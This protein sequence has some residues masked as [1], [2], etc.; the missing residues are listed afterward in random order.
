[1]A[2]IDADSTDLLSAIA[3]IGAVPARKTNP[4]APPKTNLAKARLKAGITQEQMAAWV[5]LSLRHY[6]RLETANDK[7]RYGDPRLSVLVNCALALHVPFDEVAPTSWKKTW[8]KFSRQGPER[9]P[10]E[11]VVK[12]ARK[13]WDGH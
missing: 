13:T 8:T 5:G 4:T 9:P 6:R 3:I 2:P 7:T 10:T 1:M 11:R 12:K